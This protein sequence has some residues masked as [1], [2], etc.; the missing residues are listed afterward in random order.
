[1]RLGVDDDD[2]ASRRAHRPPQQPVRRGAPRARPHAGVG[3]P[4][5]QGVPDPSGGRVGAGVH[6]DGRSDL[7]AVAH[8]H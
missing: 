8:E 1:M 7:P 4:H 3:P 2:A 5:A 6:R